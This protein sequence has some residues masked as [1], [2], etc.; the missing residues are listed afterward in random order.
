M[1]IDNID[2]QEPPKYTGE[3]L[4]LGEL[5]TF[6]YFFENRA[7]PFSKTEE[8]EIRNFKNRDWLYVDYE[9]DASEIDY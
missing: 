7:T 9:I 4:E 3:L 5:N 8:E 1:I 6:S 2:L